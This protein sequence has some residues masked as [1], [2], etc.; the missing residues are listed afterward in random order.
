MQ[1]F[2]GRHLFLLCSLLFMFAAGCSANKVEPVQYPSL[3][4]PQDLESR[5]IT[6]SKLVVKLPRGSK[7][8]TIKTGMLCVPY[9]PLNWR[10]TNGLNISDND[11]YAIFYEDLKQ[12]NYN[13]VGD[14]GELFD[15]D[16]TLAE[17]LIGGL[18]TTMDM[19]ICYPM[20]GFGNTSSGSSS[21]S[22]EVEW[23]VF[24]ALDRATVYKTSS[25]GAANAQFSN[26]DFTSVMYE[27]FSN[28][29]NGLLADKKFYELVTKQGKSSKQA[30]QEAAQFNPALFP[31]SIGKTPRSLTDVQKSV[32]TVQMGSGHGS[33]FV[34]A[35]HG[36]I[37]TNQHV[38]KNA[39]SVRITTHDGKK[40]Q[41]YVVA[42]D[43]ERDVA[44][45]LASGLNQPPL[46]V[47][48]GALTVG[49]EIFAIGSPKD[50]YM[51]GTVTK[52]IVSSYRKLGTQ[53]WIQGDAAINPGNSGGP[54]VDARGHLVGISTLG[55]VDAQGIFFYA[56]I[57]A[58]LSMV[59]LLEK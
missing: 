56:P 39:S 26:G 49:E 32:V 52:G 44:L 29:L 17:Y 19:D 20:T 45:V 11:F 43:A 2:R 10:G 25:K 4:V 47:R 1:G 14:P 58:A 28:A 9:G 12:L 51:S 16:R 13:V 57:E 37:V 15:N 42:R 48:K 23:Q 30:Q 5:P 21:A 46:E 53:M 34:I 18:V 7:I 50:L 31:Y 24:N 41:G 22:I 59:G 40:Y 3:N 55:R 36:L 35:D 38:V 33:G 8:G 27:A 54:L 6:M